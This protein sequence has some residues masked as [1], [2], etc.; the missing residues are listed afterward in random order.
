[1]NRNEWKTKGTFDLADY[2]RKLD[3]LKP[4]CIDPVD[5][6]HHCGGNEHLSHSVSPAEMICGPPKEKG[7]D[8]HE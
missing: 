3:E 5:S 4:V 2:Q 6:R 1:M 8:P 7:S